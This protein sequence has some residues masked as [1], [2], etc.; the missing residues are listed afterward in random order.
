MKHI[1]WKGT[2][3]KMYKKAMAL[4]KPEHG[5][6]SAN[7]GCSLRGRITESGKRKRKRERGKLQICSL[8]DKL[9]ERRRRWVEEITRTIQTDCQLKPT[10]NHLGKEAW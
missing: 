3:I 8:P 2:R 7:N 5:F 6:T 4:Q 10:V 1:I 9:G